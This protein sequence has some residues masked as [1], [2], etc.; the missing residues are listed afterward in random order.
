MPLREEAA[1]AAAATP[2]LF[3][4]VIH[5][6]VCRHFKHCITAWNQHQRPTV[7]WFDPRHCCPPAPYRGGLFQL[8]DCCAFSM[9][10][11]LVI[12]LDLDGGSAGAPARGGLGAKLLRS[13]SSVAR[14]GRGDV[15]GVVGVQCNVVE[16]AR[17][18]VCKCSIAITQGLTATRSN[19]D[20]VLPLL[21]WCGR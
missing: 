12:E 17:G 6:R 21:I 2:V 19:R 9:T 14:G 10:S 15:C 3:N 1:E 7:P 20:S 8:V 18:G 4:D 11:S 5:N 13:T 16:R